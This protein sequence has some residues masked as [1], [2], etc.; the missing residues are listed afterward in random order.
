VI[1]VENI[2][3]QSKENSL[4][5]FAVW[6]HREGKADNT[7]KTYLSILEK[8][9][10]WLITKEKDLNAIK[11]NDVQSYMDYLEEQQKNACTIEK[12]LAAISVFSRFSGD[13][14]II[15][16]IK[17]KEKSRDYD[18]PEYL[19]ESEVKKLLSEIELSNSNRNVAIIYTLLHTGIRIS[20]LCALNRS[21]V[22]IKDDKGKLIV[23]NKDKIDRV[24]PLSKDVIKHLCNYIKSLETSND[25][26]FVS[27]VN[28]RISHR[29][30]QYMLEKYHVNPHK[31]RHTFCK[32]LI[33][34][35]V[36]IHTVAKLAGHKDINVTKRYVNEI[37]E[38]NLEDAIDKA[39]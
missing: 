37:E 11:S 32:Q 35:G 33:N 22:D 6:L 23:R 38:V 8:F 15:L 18:V 30:V 5:D 3:S 10:T 34:N 28:R 26:L 14:G 4:G 21:D 1:N 9:Q 39:F 27:S 25:A 36:D 20:E 16:N 12:Y 29:G 13:T 31:L 2:D 17:R 7:I 19:D 24:I